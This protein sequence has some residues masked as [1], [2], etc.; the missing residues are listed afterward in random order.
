[1]IVRSTSWAVGTSLTYVC[2]CISVSSEDPE[3]VDN[4]SPCTY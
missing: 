3:H 4:R 2:T 1:M